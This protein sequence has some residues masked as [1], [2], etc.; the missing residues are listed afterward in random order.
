MDSLV[1]QDHLLK[2]LEKLISFDFARD[3]TKE[4]YFHT[5]KPSIDPIVLVKMI[6]VG[7]LFDIRQEIKLIE[8]IS[9]NLLYLSG[10]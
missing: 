2:R 9:L 1:L 3:I 4:Y 5:G 7:Y 6:L 10:R 8:K